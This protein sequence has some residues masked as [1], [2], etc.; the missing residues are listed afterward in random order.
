MFDQESTK[1]QGHSDE[2]IAS[3][4]AQSKKFDLQ[5]ALKE[6][7]S[8]Q[9]IINHLSKKEDTGKAPE[10]VTTTVTPP[11]AAR[12][13]Y[14]AAIPPTVL[15][16]AKSTV[17]FGKYAGEEG[18]EEL[19]G[20]F[21]P[22]GTTTDP[23][24]L[25]EI[26]KGLVTGEKKIS[27]YESLAKET[28]SAAEW[29]AFPAAVRT[30]GAIVKEVLPK[31]IVEFMGKQR[32]FP[33]QK[34]IAP[35][36][37]I[38]PGITPELIVSGIEG[39]PTIK[40]KI[41][42]VAP[43]VPPVE[44]ITKPAVIKTEAK[45]EVPITPEILEGTV[46][47]GQT[48]P[49]PKYAEKSSINLERLETTDDVKH[50]INDLT[51]EQEL[52]IGKRKVSWEETSQKAEELGWN[53]DEV[54]KAFQRKGSFSA[55]E[56][57]A[58]RQ[59]N[60]NAITD[61]H[62]MLRTLPV[63]RT[64][65][66]PE[67]R[68][69]VLDAID[70]VRVTSQASTEAGRALNIHKKILARDEQFKEA[71][72]LNRVLKILEG[73]GIKRADDV[74]DALRN[75]DFNNPS[76][77][78]RFVYNATK[79]R[80]QKMS[81]RAYEIWINGLLSNPMTH[82]VNTTSNTL[83]L[84]GQY[85]ERLLGAGIEKVRAGF[86]IFGGKM[87]ERFMGETAQD[88]FSTIQGIK[89]G[90][91][92]FLNAMKTGKM[93][94]TKLETHISTLPTGVQ[95]FTPARALGAEDEYFKGF[96]QN[97]ELNRLA[98]RKAIQEGLKGQGKRDR[99]TDLLSR[100]TEEMLE[101]A[102]QK[103]KYLTYQQELGKVG[104]W[105]MRGRQT[106]PGLKY[107]IPF[108]RTPA[109]IVKFALERTPANIPRI[110]YKTARGEL[111]GGPL[112]EDVA[113]TLTGSMLGFSSYL[114]A[115]EGYIT[116]GGPKGPAER[117]ELFRTGWLPY[118]FKLGD[119]YYSFARLEPLAS[120]LGI[121]ADFAELEKHM[122]EDEKVKVAAVIGTSISKNFT[123]KTFMQGFSNLNDAISDPGRFGEKFIQ[124]LGG[125]VIPSVSGGITRA[126]DPEIREVRGILDTVKS[127]I[128]G[129]SET[130]P[131]K[132]NVWGEPIE[133]PGSPALRF[134]SPIQ[135]SELKG[136]PIDIEL[137]NLKINLGMPSKKVKNIEL[138]PNEYRQMVVDA[139][140]IAKPE[141]N[142]L[143]QTGW[144][145]KLSD[146]EKEK[147]IRGV[148]RESREDARNLALLSAEKRIATAI[149]GSPLPPGLGM[150]MAEPKPPMRSGGGTKPTYNHLKYESE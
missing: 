131:A 117:D 47:G 80:W 67:M 116:G 64:G 62:E 26:E 108:V 85:P 20:D 133:R 22:T 2:E 24:K 21:F 17:P 68:A 140:K 74:I 7:Y 71:S 78:N 3:S 122:K 59:V 50:F 79:T 8:H 46:K 141:L 82:I 134:L 88:A 143:V 30:G 150:R 110:A 36:I 138:E 81:D 72:Q 98:Y 87:Q 99:I 90:T 119:K 137:L 89:N 33:W 55:A 124:N 148:M 107:F 101:I 28:M 113:K 32:L 114:M 127:R 100:P 136:D 60:I 41:P 77:V 75:V 70:S 44:A 118:A 4:L 6:G 63:E 112:S 135:V 11:F 69:K 84:M 23:E 106:V 9:E 56:I 15:E 126:I 132:I 66:T 48:G 129:L 95:K 147:E 42:V 52:K 76:E 142:K 1:K 146:E 49:L 19:K 128:P 40:P 10:K 13:P 123:S 58:T 34:L 38:K 121:S 109:N 111:S 57:E 31:K 51:K 96:I 115:K 120:I 35:K 92:R 105:I 39:K 16:V 93:A 139:G 45:V 65:Y 83:T 86:G 102:A 25:K 97:A 54:K 18:R 145:K 91:K 14:L 37:E 130:L 53:V 149:T 73:K 104:S 5:G 103:A 125:S 61:L 27:P 12:H 29:A 43:E 144:Y 94:E